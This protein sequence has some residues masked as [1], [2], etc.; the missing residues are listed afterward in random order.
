[1]GEGGGVAAKGVQRGLHDNVPVPGTKLGKSCTKF[2]CCVEYQYKTRSSTFPVCLWYY[3]MT[4]T[5]GY[6]SV[7][8]HTVQSSLGTC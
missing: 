7:F 4:M 5:P 1:M 3:T 6:V 8:G 2:V